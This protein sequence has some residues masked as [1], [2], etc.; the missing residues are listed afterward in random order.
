MG[1]QASW[2]STA[3]FGLTRLASEP[4][5]GSALESKLLM[6]RGQGLNSAKSD[7]WG[8]TNNIRSICLLVSYNITPWRSIIA[9][10]ALLL[11]TWTWNRTSI[12][13]PWAVCL[14]A[15]IHATTIMNINAEAVPHVC[16][17][18]YIHRYLYI[19]ICVYLLTQRCYLGTQRSIQLGKF[20]DRGDRAP[21]SISCNKS[22]SHHRPH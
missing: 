13:V 15:A 14:L 8:A 9:Y 1:W 7:I 21:C 11:R 4:P 20:K 10:R 18:R 12:A 17:I 6:K 5:L 22:R 16:I 3:R 19:D 2:H